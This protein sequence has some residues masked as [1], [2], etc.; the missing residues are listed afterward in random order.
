MTA[1]ADRPA[2][3]PATAE[4]AAPTPRRT[5]VAPAGL[6][7]ATAILYLVN[8]S[9][10]GFGN[11]F[12]AA[13][14]QA[15]SQS[16]SAWFFGSLDAQ[17]FI[18]VD[19]PP[20]SLWVMGASA[21][22]F[23]MN[24]WALL[25]PN[26]LMGVAAVAVLYATVR[27][28]MPDPRQGAI[29]GLI[30]GGVLAFTPA[31]A[32]IFR[33]DNPDALLALLVVVAAYCLTRAVATTSW[34]WLALVGVALGFAFLTKMLEGLMVLPGFALTY[35][36]FARTGWIRRIVHLLG[37]AAALVVSAGWWVLAVQLVPA[38]AR[39][40]VGGSTDNTVLQL[41][42][43]YNGITR[44]LGRSG[45]DGGPPP[46]GGGPGGPGGW[47]FGGRTGLHRLFT[48][49]MGNEISWLLPVA[50]FVIAFGGYLA[51]RRRLTRGELTA[52]VLWGGW[53]AV[54]GVVFSYMNGIVHPYYTVTMAPAV[55]ALVGL[56]GVWAW[57][58]RTAW[59][60]RIAL[61]VMITLAA[62]WSVILL[63]RA[64]FGPGW[65]HWGM[66]AFAAAA[67]LGVLLAGVAEWDRTLAAAVA[68]GIVAG[69]GGTTAFAIE[70]AATA[71][72]G[73]LPNAV[74]TPDA[75]TINVPPRPAGP[76]GFGMAEQ[77][78]TEVATLLAATDTRWSAATNG[79]QAA[80]ALELSSG[81][82]VMAIGG[83]SS[84]PVP[85]LQQFIDDVHA[86]R[87]G[88]Y[89]VGGRGGRGGPGGPGSFGGAGGQ[90]GRDHG[91]PQAQQIQDWVAHNF[92]AAK[93]GETTVYRLT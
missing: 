1:V 19:K 47:A 68:A 34:R 52:L 76:G 43:G 26:A 6:L 4:P 21:R 48:A 85:T 63:D 74:R 66:T 40:Y 57:R 36:L 60:G 33:F 30:A 23:G 45:H 72:N 55:G 49:E 90:G 53:L 13:A 54:T 25:V 20:A 89:V 51:V 32:L 80:A 91:S 22:L 75:Q 62:G 8:L 3:A 11:R 93:V 82:P 31:A 88:Y 41:A 44:I 42:L 24:S 15:G 83:W 69:A 65:I 56:G 67:A 84:D 73:S 18:T 27:R 70:T 59:D 78:N 92:T 46:G 9:A 7:A 79:S 10:N 29:A 28:A 77:P 35:L 81:T 58:R 16:W 17:N 61:A 50:L 5:R 37:A 64:A 14:A 2:T 86:G 12:Y 71:H 87:I 39:P 38:S